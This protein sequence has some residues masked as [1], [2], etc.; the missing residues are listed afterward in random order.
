MNAYM[1]AY[2]KQYVKSERNAESNWHVE[3]FADPTDA[4]EYLAK[5]GI[6]TNDTAEDVRIYSAGGKTMQLIGE[7]RE[8][9]FAGLV[10]NAT[11]D[12][13]VM[14]GNITQIEIK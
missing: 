3:Y 8:E 13:Y 10:E 14:I 9:N 6:K 7:R 5:H 11:K 12:E 1:T 4:L 2:A